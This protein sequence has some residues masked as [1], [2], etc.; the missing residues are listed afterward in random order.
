MAIKTQLKTTTDKQGGGEREESKEIAFDDI[1]VWEISHGWQNRS[2]LQLR[3]QLLRE[4]DFL[5]ML[6]LPRNSWHFY[7]CVRCCLSYHP[8]LARATGCECPASWVVCKKNTSHSGSDLPFPSLSLWGGTFF[9]KPPRDFSSGQMPRWER[10]SYK[11]CTDFNEHRKREEL[12]LFL[13]PTRTA[14][15][16]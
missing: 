2:G 12:C 14:L 6:F 10:L 16:R 1:C 15:P 8:H 4:K 5:Y 13:V 9:L 11:V 3:N 7:S